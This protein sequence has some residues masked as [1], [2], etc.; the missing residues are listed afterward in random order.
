MNSLETPDTPLVIKPEIQDAIE[1]DQLR[2]QQHDQDAIR[3]ARL[4]KLHQELE[5]R[6]GAFP[7]P[8]L[9]S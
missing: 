6:Y 7:K 9:S 4:V 8:L 1:Y 2:R 5:K 3:D